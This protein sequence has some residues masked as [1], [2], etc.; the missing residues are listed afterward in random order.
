M[1]RA[2]FNEKADTWDETIAEM[3][4]VLNSGGRVTI[5]H[6]K[7]RAEINEIH[8]QSPVVSN[9]IIPDAD[10]TR[11]MFSAAGFTEIRIEDGRDSYPASAWSRAKRD[12]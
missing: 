8:H 3:H 11:L 4:R 2:Y 1:I 10:E 9:D 12:Q 7:N 6:T 5:C